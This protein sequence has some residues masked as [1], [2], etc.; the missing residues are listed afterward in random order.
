MNQTKFKILAKNED[1]ILM[2]YVGANRYMVRDAEND[3]VYIGY[4]FDKAKSIFNSYSLE[5]V[6]KQRR[7]ALSEWL[8]EFVE[9]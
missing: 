6:R 8:K 4:D 2:Q 1:C 7:E 3:A 9:A 5:E